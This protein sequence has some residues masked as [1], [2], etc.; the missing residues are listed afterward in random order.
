MENNSIGIVVGHDRKQQTSL[1]TFTCNLKIKIPELSDKNVFLCI[2]NGVDPADYPI[3]CSV[4]IRYTRGTG[5]IPVV[6]A[7]LIE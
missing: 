6:K 1:N 5:R 2:T 3:G 7:R 4:N